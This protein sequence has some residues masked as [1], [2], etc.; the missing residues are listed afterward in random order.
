MNFAVEVAIDL[1]RSAIRDDA[2]EFDA[3]ANEGD[4]V[5]GDI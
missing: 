3:L 5:F 2:L 4:D 1:H